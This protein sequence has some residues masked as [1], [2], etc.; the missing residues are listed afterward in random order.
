MM[1]NRK[2]KEVDAKDTSSE[3]SFTLVSPPKI[4]KSSLADDPVTQEE[5]KED[6]INTMAFRKR[7][8]K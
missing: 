6:D 1:P 8:P 4:K 3:A 7:R 5:A 2:V